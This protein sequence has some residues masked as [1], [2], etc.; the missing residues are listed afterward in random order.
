MSSI[1]AVRLDENACIASTKNIIP[2][3]GGRVKR[4]CGKVGKTVT[5]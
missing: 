1:A 2:V 4:T 3:I 5:F